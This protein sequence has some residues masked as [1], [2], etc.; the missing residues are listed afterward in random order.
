MTALC[1]AALADMDGGWLFASLVWGSVGAGYW[2]Y[3]K[4]QHSV[5]ALIGGAA[6]V[7]ISYFIPSPLWMSLAAIAIIAGIW[8]W[9]RR[10]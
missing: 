10:E 9:S 1:G 8:M 7:A 4:K 3:A 2:V 5:P 6:L